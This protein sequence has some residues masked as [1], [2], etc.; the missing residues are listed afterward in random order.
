MYNSDAN[1]YQ[2]YFDQ[3]KDFTKNSNIGSKYL[4]EA[5]EVIPADN[6]QI[7]RY[8]SFQYNSHKNKESINTMGGQRIFLIVPSFFNSPEILFLNRGRHFIDHLRDLGEVYIINWLEI[9]N[10]SFS[11]DDYVMGVVKSLINVSKKTGK[12]ID[13]IGHCI[14][15]NV[16]IAATVI[17]NDLVNTLT[18]LTS[19]WD[20]TYLDLL[21]P[22]QAFFNL[23]YHVRQ[24]AIIPKLYIQ[25]LF[26]LLFPNYFDTKLDK[27]F[28]F[29]SNEEKELFFKVEHWL[30]S[31]TSL[32][33]ATYFQLI[34]SIIGDNIQ[35]KKDWRVNGQI[36]DP[37]LLKQPVCLILAENDQIVPQNSILP[38][39]KIFK[40]STIV[41]VEGG[42]ISYLISSKINYLFIVY[43]NFLESVIYYDRKVENE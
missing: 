26:F 18:L 5:T 16:A 6:C 3:Y 15:G 2:L 35:V 32:P 43:K 41:N 8:E 12:Q 11:L 1:K 42:H 31:G 39:Y 24:C 4:T 22:T 28:T 23:D 7:L 20:F 25:I 19:P 34:N 37:S 36:I 29:T 21:R 13:L 38:L 17:R 30:M 9:D 33:S 27:Y 40:K 10:P 14:G